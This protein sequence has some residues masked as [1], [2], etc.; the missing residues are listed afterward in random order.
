MIVFPNAKINLGLSVTEKRADGFHNVETIFYPVPWTDALEIIPSEN[1]EFSLTGFDIQTA[2]DENL[3]VKVYRSLKKEFNLPEVRMHLHKVIPSGAGLGGGSSDAAF[4]IKLLNK[5]FQLK[6]SNEE[7][8][9]RIKIFGSDCAFFIK[10]KP[11]SASGK[12]DIFQNSSVNLNRKF[13]V[14]I[15]PG[16]QVSTKEAYQGIKP[17]IP[18]IKVTEA[19]TKPYNQ[20][21]E[22]LINDFEKTVFASQ[23]LLSEIKAELY[24]KGAIYA[25]M[26]GSG[27]A[28]Y[29]IFEKETDLKEKFPANW[30]VWKGMLE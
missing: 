7:I 18:G 17:G 2:T 3:C 5:L 12:G 22:L 26:S 1:F 27:S 13:L 20:W 23:P 11:V 25:S 9:S 21:K 29:G 24:E 14:I 8:I 28:V 30:K 6:L 16:V 10:N 4:T 19:I 15:Y